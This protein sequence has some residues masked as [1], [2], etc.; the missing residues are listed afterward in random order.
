MFLVISIS[1]QAVLALAAPIIPLARHH[2]AK[3][4]CWKLLMVH[5][6]PT[7]PPTWR[8]LAV[9]PTTCISLCSTP[10]C[11]L[12]DSH[13][14]TTTG[15]MTQLGKAVPLNGWA[16]PQPPLGTLFLSQRRPRPGQLIGGAAA[17]QGWQG[18]WVVWVFHSLKVMLTLT[19]ALPTC[20]VH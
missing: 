8:E 2:L 16:W 4:R 13:C 6:N 12:P 18:P 11:S 19:T 14:T 5:P 7:T 15:P 9:G 17:H 1:C 10:W 20:C 3:A